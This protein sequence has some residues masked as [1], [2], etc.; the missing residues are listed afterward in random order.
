MPAKL[1]RQRDAI[2]G[3]KN[4][5]S[6][7]C[8]VSNDLDIKVQNQQF[9]QKYTNWMAAWILANLSMDDSLQRQIENAPKTAWEDETRHYECCGTGGLLSCP[10]F[11]CRIL[12]PG[13]EIEL[14]SP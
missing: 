11:K 3:K 1:Q 2:N 5:N 12:V 7:L 10:C 6:A 13:I 9:L 4:L 14:L 8:L